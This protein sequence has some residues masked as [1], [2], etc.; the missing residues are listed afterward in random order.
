MRRRDLNA[1]LKQAGSVT[2]LARRIG[3][4]PSTVKRWFAPGGKVSKAAEAKLAAFRSEHKARRARARVEEQEFKDALQE[5]KQDARWPKYRSGQG[6]RRGPTSVGYKWTRLVKRELS[7]EVMFEIAMWARTLKQRFPLWQI[8]LATS[9]LVAGP[10]VPFAQSPATKT[11]RVYPSV[12]YAQ[13]RTP[14]LSPDRFAIEA[15]IVTPRS[16]K[17]MELLASLERMVTERV[18]DGNIRIFVHTV[19]VYNYRLRTEEERR[20][21][22]SRQRSMRY[23]K[24]KRR[25]TRSKKGG[26]R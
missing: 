16:T 20:K 6:E 19:T 11:G 9:Q 22:Q 26:A 5:A 7:S 8:A 10:Q 15:P 23:T 1:L 2:E 3:M 21:W 13:G 12:V 4:A 24:A 14:R 18:A 17:R 25:K